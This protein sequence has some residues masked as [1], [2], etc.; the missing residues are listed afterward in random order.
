MARSLRRGD[1]SVGWVCA[2]PVELTA[3]QVL[4]D[5]EHQDL[6]RSHDDA[7]IYTLGR[8]GEHN[9]VIACLPAGQTGTN[10]A[11]VVAK[12]MKSTFRAI[13]LGLMVGIG[14]GVPSA[15][16]DIRLGDIVVSQPGKGHGGVI[17]FDFGK[18]KPNEFER[19]GFLNTPPQILLS[20]VS[21]LRANH[22][23]GKSDLVTHISKLGKLPGYGREN[24]GD[25]ILFEGSYSHVEGNNC[26]SC[27]N[28]RK[29]QRKARTEATP[30]VHYGT[31]ASA[32]Q[33]M[34]DGRTRDRT[35]SEFG[36]VLC[37]E[38]EAAGLMNSFPCLVI[39]GICDYADSHKNKRWQAYA[40]G[41]AA[42]YAKELL[43]VIPTAN[44][45]KR[46]TVG[47]ATTGQSQTPSAYRDDTAIDLYKAAHRDCH[48]L[49]LRITNRP[50]WKTILSQARIPQSDLLE[51]LSYYNYQR[52]YSRR[53]RKKLK[54]TTEWILKEPD[55]ESWLHNGQPQCL[56]LSGIIGSGKSVT[57]TTMI[58]KASIEAQKTGKPVLY[59]FFDH[60]FRP[61]LTARS[62]F[63]SYT[64]QLLYY[65]ELIRKSCPHDVIRQIVEF[66]GPKKRPPSLD[67]VVDELIIPLLTTA[68]ECIF[69]VDGL[70]E[71]STKE[72]Q[73]VLKVFKKLLATPSCRGL[74]ACREE[75][76][77]ARRIPGSVRI[78]I[79]PEKLKA[80]MKLFVGCKLEEMQSNRRISESEDMLTYIE[81]EL[82]K[83][84]DR[85]FL[86]A[87]LQIQLLWDNC[88][89]ED[90]V[91]DTI[92]QSLQQ[93]PEDLNEIYRACQQKAS[94]DEKKQSLAN[95]ALKLLCAAVEP[96]RVSQLREALVV[97]PQ[98]GE[99]KSSPIQEDELIACCASFIYLEH[100]GE[101]ELVLLAHYSVRQFLLATFSGD[102][103]ATELELG[104]L[105]I[106]HLHRHMPVRDLTV[107][108]QDSSLA[109]RQIN[110]PMPTNIGSSVARIVAQQLFSF[111][112][113]RLSSVSSI[114]LSAPAQ[115][116]NITFDR[117][118]FLYYAKKHWT[119]LTRR[120]SINS[121]SYSK[122]EEVALSNIKAWWVFPWQRHY[123]S[124]H[125]S[126]VF[127]IYGWSIMNSHYG[128]LALAIDQQTQVHKSIY[129]LPVLGSIEK[130]DLLPFQAV[131]EV[132]DVEV[133]KL[134]LKILPQ[135]DLEVGQPSPLHIAVQKSY[136]PMRHF[137]LEAGV[138]RR[139]AT[140]EGHSTWVNAVAFSPDGKTLA[141]ASGDS[142]V[143]L[144][145]ARSG[146]TLATLEG[147][148]DWVNAVAFSPDGKTLASASDD[149]TI[150]LW[151][152]GSGAALATLKGHS[153]MVNAVAFSP[154]GK[155]LASASNDSTV[156]LWGARS[157][158]ATLATLEGHSKMVN[159]VAFS[160]DGKTLASASHDRTIRLWDARSGATL[161]TLKGH[162]N[163]V[164]AVAFSPDGKTL[165]SAS[166]DSTVRLWDARSGATL[167]TLEGHSN[168]VNA[169]AFSPD[170]KTLA[171]ASDDRTV[172][173]WD[174][175]SGATL[176]TLEGHSNWVRA[177]AFSPDGKTLASASHD[178]TVRLWDAR[179]GAM[180]VTLES[181]SSAVNA[182]TFSPDS[183][184]LA[185]ASNDS[186][187]RLWDA[188]PGVF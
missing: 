10:S 81:Q 139:L 113:S 105:C 109:R 92:Y 79:T 106:T 42:A 175:R 20:A 156:R 148:S 35:S 29:V 12:Q 76:D 135:K 91:D 128:L 100:D 173:L 21:K 72:T 132:G 58:N 90:A 102:Y 131:A 5:E 117:K 129:S 50:E 144:W 66:Y 54:H 55:F 86:W 74:I 2:L 14:G 150:R 180:L 168:W 18:S 142:T 9:V 97:D 108:G 6:P 103:D 63:E 80:D 172:R 43:L 177:V 38:M 122:F 166:V 158:A 52:E 167:A 7:N 165:A 146:A 98:S 87:E 4:L 137:L 82:M 17:Q 25:D 179:S 121:S 70:N 159:A 160:P 154:D 187:V 136:E 77:I 112:T 53:A 71:C 61:H 47:N 162:S 23:R 24:T 185:S 138:S 133:A 84:A 36:G 171:S 161:A 145:D 94:R 174:A 39:R 151:D 40:A 147:H 182:V 93:L 141:S 163:W 37:F 62:L 169:V 134:L 48:L 30:K 59:Y 16:E 188:S 28:A 19:T 186:A 114:R 27:V 56:W 181:H 107:H 153:K 44:V 34:R 8:I 157:G 11:A 32:N 46:Q 26:V 69:I 78:R 3:A 126:H 176:A 95:K 178:S 164:R 22:D 60:S 65:L 75:V 57:L 183:K 120:I 33:V 149:R 155:T 125:P 115:R 184:T 111:R 140:L 1:Y 85:M 73:E 116:A 170:G 118:T 99:L 49:D 143:R 41:T 104:E 45:V 51:R 124:S 127:A 130:R 101:D 83:R 31:I 13:Q 119:S 88:S 15:E 96:F 68:A 67:E 110:L 123:E 152:A 64:K 89:G